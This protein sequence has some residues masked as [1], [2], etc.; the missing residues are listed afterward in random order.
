[1]YFT[2]LNGLLFIFFLLLII[3]GLRLKFWPY[4]PIN[5]IGLIIIGIT[6]YLDLNHMLNP[7]N[8]IILFAAV[9]IVFITDII[10]TFREF[11]EEITEFEAKR[12]RRYLNALD[13]SG[14]F[15]LIGD[16]Q[17]MREEIE[18][19][20]NISM[21]DQMQALAMFRLGNKAYQKGDYQEALD[22]YDLSTNW[23]Q[24]GI[25]LLNQSGILLQLGQ[26]EDA[27]VMAE[28]AAE[29][30][31][32]FYEALLNQAV[33]LEK[34]K[35]YDQALMKFKAAAAISPD[36]YEAWLCCAHILFK[37]NKPMEAIEYYNKAIDL[38]SRLYEAY[39]YKGV[40]LQKLG[41]DV[42]ALRCF[43]QVI[44]LNP[45]HYHA[46][47]RAGNILTKLDRT[48]EAI[49]AYEKAIKL[50][51]DLLTAWN[52]LGVVLAK[53]GRIKD[54]MKCYERAIKINPDYH[55]AWLNLGLAQDNSGQYR[56]AYFSYHRFLDLAPTDLEKRIAITRKRVE[57]L[58]EKYKLKPYKPQK[59]APS[60]KSKKFASL[61]EE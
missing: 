24:T 50:N 6:F 20:K 61:T 42:D 29:V 5:S 27:Y 47:H 34:M 36:E 3:V 33:A 1:M 28:K 52:N 9:L 11:K 35:K 23:V 40:C 57:E 56:K 48:N 15:K 44:K 17:L 7:I 16:E 13:N 53:V 45:E 4:I 2:I 10:Y 58:R 51:S 30:R 55:E 26:F 49:R 25:G 19:A 46:H 21:Q 60:K 14:H 59:K 41:Q 18:Q 39:Y 37:M 54:A 38:H 32:N 22:K 8:I 31:P 12:L 43:E